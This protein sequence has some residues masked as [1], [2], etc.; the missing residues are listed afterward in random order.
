[1]E[2]KKTSTQAKHLFEPTQVRSMT[3]NNRIIRAALWLKRADP[4]GHL[5]Q[6]IYDYYGELAAGGVGLIIT[7]YSMVDAADRPNPGMMGIYSDEFIPEHKRLV[8]LAHQHGTPIALQMAYG[9]SQT[10]H[11]E[12]VKHP[13]IGPSAVQNR[14]TKVIP[15][16]MTK[17]DILSVQEHFAA[18]AARAQAAGYDAIELHAAHG[19]LLSQFLT[20]YCNRR[21][22]EYGGSLENRARILCE[23]IQAVRA[24]VGEDFP[25]MV[26]FNHDDYMDEGEGLTLPEAVEVAKML[27][28]AG[29]DMLEVSG[30]N[31]TTGKGVGPARTGINKPEKQSY[32]LEPTKLIAEAVSIP[33]ILMGGNR[34][35][36]RLESL[37]ESTSI[38]YFAVAR[39]LLAEPDLPKKWQADLG[40]KPMCVSC[41]GC[42]TKGDTP[43][44]CVVQARLKARLQAKAAKA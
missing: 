24:R 33:V 18:S 8:D 22:D 32:Y 39:P 35:A 36:Q 19:Y 21:E 40:Y 38:A 9:G 16:E 17:E 1:M 28:A 41:N 42:Y 13:Q 6:S 30:C 15:R 11:P 43:V 20:P 2:T 37:L 27:E 29:A 44:H 25:I 3:I 12:Y 14:V 23:T 34:D 26:K 10:M 7:G 31:E 5:T 4:E